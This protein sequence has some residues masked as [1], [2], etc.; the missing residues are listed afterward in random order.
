MSR[1]SILACV[2]VLLLNFPAFAGDPPRPAPPK[3]AGDLHTTTDLSEKLRRGVLITVDLA[4]ATPRSRAKAP[5]G[6]AS[7]DLRVGYRFSLAKVFLVAEGDFGGYLF[8]KDTIGLRLGAGGRFG[9]DLGRF[10][11]S[12]HAYGGWAGTVGV[13]GAGVRAGLALDVRALDFLSPGIHVDFN[14][15]SWGASQRPALAAGSTE[16]LS[17]GAHVGF[18]L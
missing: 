9:V 2:S 8:P 1:S 18:I 10:E 4:G 11:P 14:H 12:V 15:A 7:L 16:F 13:Y 3:P 17:I 5:H 6:G